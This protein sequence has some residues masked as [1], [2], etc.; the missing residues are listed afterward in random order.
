MHMH[1]IFKTLNTKQAQTTLQC[2]DASAS[3]L[4]INKKHDKPFTI[5][6]MV[7]AKS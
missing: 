1:V 6:F 2:V 4:N 3:K 5:V 7:R